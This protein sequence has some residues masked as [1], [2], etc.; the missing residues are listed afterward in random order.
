[1]G[2]IYQR[3]NTTGCRLS[4]EEDTLIWFANPSTGNI[5]AK[6]T[7]QAIVQNSSSTVKIWQY[8]SLWK[9]KIPLKIK[10]F[11][12]LD[13]QNCL[14][15]WDKLIRKGW[16]GPKFCILCKKDA[17]SVDHL[18]IHCSFTVNIWKNVC[19]A[20]KIP[21]ILKGYNIDD[22]C[23]LCLKNCKSHYFLL[24]IISWKIWN[25]RDSYFF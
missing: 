3:L 14:K 24:A 8:K 11:M 17:E 21:R 20:L 15:T 22:P 6:S 18:M 4:E 9:W 2:R 23:Y 19:L 16:Y 12:W 10:C 25:V 7:Y 13:L 1:M 5:T